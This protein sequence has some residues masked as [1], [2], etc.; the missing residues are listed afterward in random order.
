[1]AIRMIVTDMDGT[2]LDAKNRVSEANRAALA[3]AAA[4]GVHVAI[5]TG[6]MHA[7][8][9]PY[10]KEIGVTAPIISCNGALVKTTA[11]EELFSAPIAPDAVRAVLD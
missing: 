3:E 6:R 8:A 11:G 9:L 5:A 4:E 1:M 7:S 10:A 2:L